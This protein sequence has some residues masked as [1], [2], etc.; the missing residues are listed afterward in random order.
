MSIIFNRVMT[1]DRC[2]YRESQP[3]EDWFIEK[4]IKLS[5]SNRIPSN[6]VYI[7]GHILCPTCKTKTLATAHA[8]IQCVMTLTIPEEAPSS[9]S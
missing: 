8:Y 5:P 6:W 9:P 3:I 1:C 7:G 4:L 2:G